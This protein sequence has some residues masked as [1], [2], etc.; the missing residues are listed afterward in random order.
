MDYPQSFGKQKSGRRTR[1]AAA[2]G[3][4]LAAIVAAAPASAQELVHRFVSPGFGGNPFNADYLLNTANIHRPSEPEPPAEPAPSEEELIARQIQARFLSQL[5]SD[6]SSAIQNAQPGDSGEF[7]L[8]DQIIRF[9]RTATE[10]RITFVNGRTG[11]SSELVIPASQIASLLSG[12]GTS[13]VGLSNAKSAEQ[14][15]GAQGSGVGTITGVGGLQ[16]LEGAGSLEARLQTP[17]F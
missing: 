17:G 8:G 5:S 10:T 2:A 15:L 3:V 9:T 6:I 1:L 16:S 11:T 13:A 14:A 12:A 7:T 4:A